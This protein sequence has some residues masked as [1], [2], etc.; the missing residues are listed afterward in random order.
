MQL[1]THIRTKPY[2]HKKNNY[3]LDASRPIKFRN[4]AKNLEL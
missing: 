1:P 2:N 3:K 4:F